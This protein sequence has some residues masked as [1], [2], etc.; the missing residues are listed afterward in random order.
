MRA[1]MAVGGRT[2]AAWHPKRQA[3]QYM[4]NR[5]TDRPTHPHLQPE[6]QRCGGQR[7]AQHSGAE[8]QLAAGLQRPG[9][10]AAQG[11]QQ[12]KRRVQDLS[13]A[14]QGVGNARRAVQG[15]RNVIGSWQWVL[16][17]NGVGCVELMHRQGAAAQ[18]APN[19]AKGQNKQFSNVPSCR[20]T[21]SEGLSSSSR[22]AEGPSAARKARRSCRGG[23]KRGRVGRVGA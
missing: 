19:E 1:G 5:S 20:R 16:G 8:A 3:G 21:L 14:V 15:G 2:R 17:K 6:V 12:G 11:Q 7:K 22:S 10:G 18:R 4:P 23:D 13:G 9:V